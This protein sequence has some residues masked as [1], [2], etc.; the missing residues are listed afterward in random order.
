M[1]IS[2]SNLKSKMP[3][4]KARTCYICGR[5][6]LLPGFAQHVVQCRELFEK[7]EILKP[8]KERRPCPPD[9]MLFSSNKR[10]YTENELAL[11]NA[12]AMKS[13]ETTLSQCRNCGRTFLPEKLA[14]H[15][16]SCTSSNPARSVN[17]GGDS[18]RN[19]E[20]GN[21]L[22]NGMNSMSMGQ[23]RL[24]GGRS[25][26]PYAQDDYSNQ[27][28]GGQFS[29]KSRGTTMNRTNQF[30]GD[31]NGQSMSFKKQLEAGY[32]ET[33]DYG[34]LIKCKECGR[35]FNPVSYDK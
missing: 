14:T 27:Q 12:A 34:H 29:G 18:R 32:V 1:T 3:P 31:G 20:D 26:D 28:Q 22:A 21:N 2:K 5:P 9:P 7:R 25:M 6:T 4:P 30:N 35:N 17:A 15:N 10:G 8:P 16:R 23:G 24:T 19:L 11:E 33:P 13:F